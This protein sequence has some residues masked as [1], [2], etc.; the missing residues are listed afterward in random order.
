MLRNGDQRVFIGD[1][2]LFGKAGMTVI[3]DIDDTIK[4]TQVRDRR[5][6]LRNTFLEPFAPVPG[7]AKVYSGW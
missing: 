1:V 5:A 4:I 2:S 3:S 7:M 6:A